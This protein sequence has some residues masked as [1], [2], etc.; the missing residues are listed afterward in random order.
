MFFTPLHRREQALALGPVG[1]YR[2]DE[3]PSFEQAR[4][5]LGLGA[6]RDNLAF[7]DDQDAV[8][9]FAD[10]GKN[11]A[12]DDGGAIVPQVFHQ[13]AHLDDLHRVEPA[14]RLVEHEQLRPVDDGLRDADALA[15]TVR[16]RRDDVVVAAGWR[17]TSSRR[18]E[19]PRNRPR[20]RRE[21]EIFCTLVSLKRRTVA[22][23]P[24]SPDLVGLSIIPD[25][26][27]N[28]ARRRQ[29]STTG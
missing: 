27:L 26:D 11:V 5:Q 21:E 25:H 24:T 10:L 19:R 4:R 3:P 29:Q 23:K 6:G 15:K 14:Y 17:R 2:H 16:Q 28:A 9:G 8:A 7:A 20:G 13:L 1:P 18:R 22:G 12:G